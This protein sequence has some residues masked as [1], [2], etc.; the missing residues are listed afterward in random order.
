MKR[1]LALGDSYTIGEGVTAGQ[2]WPVRLTARLREEG[3]A[4]ADPVIIAQTGWTTDELAVG[5]AAAAPAGPFSLV[6]LLIG[7]N[8]QYRGRAP[9]AYQA[10]F[11]RL[12]EEAITFAG[13]RS[14]RTLVISIPDWSVT[15][16]AAED[17]RDPAQIAAEIDTFN[18]INRAQAAAAGAAYTDV[19]PIS[20]RVAQDPG[21]LAGDGL[22]PS[23]KM[24]AAWV[25][26]LLPIAR[27]I[28]TTL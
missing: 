7:V 24:Y 28:L 6:S 20:R 13:G 15:P 11:N 27:R 5:V 26:L 3:T 19:T 10:G 9:D 23:G 16:F 14:E 25:D 2:R 4:V 21:L 22:H 18:A 12:L 17:E 8:D 1:F